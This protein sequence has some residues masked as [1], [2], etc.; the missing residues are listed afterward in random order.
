[1]TGATAAPVEAY[2]Y[3]LSFGVDGSGPWAALGCS[4]EGCQAHQSVRP[5]WSEDRP[6]YRDDEMVAVLFDFAVIDGW[7]IDV[8]AWCPV[9]YPG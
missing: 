2:G 8:G 3:D 1:M 6:A 4:G 5:A 7:T 9:H